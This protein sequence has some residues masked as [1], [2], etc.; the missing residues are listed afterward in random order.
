MAA[1]APAMAA[2]MYAPTSGTTKLLRDYLFEIIDLLVK[3]GM[4]AFNT[5]RIQVFHSIIARDDEH[6][7]PQLSLNSPST[8]PAKDSLMYGMYI[9]FC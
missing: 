4:P 3:K 6:A 1:L 8:S 9:G 7:L 5:L 2:N